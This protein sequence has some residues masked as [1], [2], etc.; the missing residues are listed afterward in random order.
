M[1]EV[2]WR[3]VETSH[4][5]VVYDDQFHNHNVDQVANAGVLVDGRHL[6]EGGQT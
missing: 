6:R 5:L 1:Q 3:P 4:Q 2:R